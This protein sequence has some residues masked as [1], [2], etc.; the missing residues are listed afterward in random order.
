DLYY[1]VFGL[2]GLLAFG[3]DPPPATRHYLEGFGDGA[4][5]DLVHL[6]C[7]TRCWA[8]VAPG[9]CTPDLSAAM[10]RHLET[11]RSRD[12]GYAASRD[13][14]EGTV[15]ACFLALGA[16]EDLKAP[17]PHRDGVLQSI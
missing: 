3:E 14:D 7:L 9:G 8:S 5:L 11:F 12:G 4:S 2:E 1:T 6:T 13:A 16:A 15:Y 17:L 10:L